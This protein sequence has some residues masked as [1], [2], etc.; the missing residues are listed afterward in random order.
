MSIDSADLA[1]VLDQLELLTGRVSST[2]D[3]QEAV[4][5]DVVANDLYDVERALRTASR[6]L[7]TALR[8]LG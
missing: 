7:E 6:R 2:A 1:S 8:R 4:G 3:R 5:N